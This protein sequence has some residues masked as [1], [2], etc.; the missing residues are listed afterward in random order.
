MAKST[1]P[2]YTFK[3]QLKAQT[4]KSS[5]RHTPNAKYQ[6]WQ[7]RD[8]EGYVEAVFVSPKSMVDAEMDKYANEQG[9]EFVAGDDQAAYY[10]NPNYSYVGDSGD[11]TNYAGSIQKGAPAQPYGFIHVVGGPHDNKAIDVNQTFG[12][13]DKTPD[14]LTDKQIEEAKGY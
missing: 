14:I 11:E 7:V 12:D 6:V 1:F 9:W 8:N 2:S 5:F 10:D 4:R 13:W 3:A